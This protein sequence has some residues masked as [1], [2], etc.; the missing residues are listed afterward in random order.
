MFTDFRSPVVMTTGVCPTGPRRPGVVIGPYAG[1]ICEEDAR[2][3]LGCQL[4][5]LRVNGLLPFRHAFRILLIS[6]VQR[7]LRRQAH[8]LE[9]PADLDL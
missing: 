2:A 9:Q 3:L 6:A 8:L 5:D 1:L 4:A 7:P